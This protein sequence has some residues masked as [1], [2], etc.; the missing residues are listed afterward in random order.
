MN[1]NHSVQT[2]SKTLRPDSSAKTTTIACLK[3]CRSLLRQVQGIKESVMREFESPTRE[4]VEMLR[5]ALK[6]AESLAWQTP[7]PHLLFPVLAQEKAESAR[8]WAERQRTVRQA[9]LAFAE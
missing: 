7:Y 1:T 5:F 6:E 4:Q 3:S 9:T 8:Q 2:K